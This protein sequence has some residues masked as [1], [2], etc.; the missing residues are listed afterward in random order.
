M[1]LTKSFTQLLVSTQLPSYMTAAPPWTWL[2]PYCLLAYES[3]SAQKS[4]RTVCTY[5]VWGQRKRTTREP[6]S[7]HKAWEPPEVGGMRGILC[8]RNEGQSSQRER[9]CNL[10][11]A[12]VRPLV[13]LDHHGSSHIILDL[14]M[15]I[16][17]CFL[18]CNPSLVCFTSHYGTYHYAE[19][20]NTWVLSVN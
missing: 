4:E 2:Q 8:L 1:R 13:D 6:L 9:V 11:R 19:K 14:Q 10:L 7:Q 18:S 3:L 17:K 20:N 15:K 12:H 16:I 5:T